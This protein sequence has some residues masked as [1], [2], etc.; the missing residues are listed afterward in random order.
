[1][2][3]T[4]EITQQ[5]LIFHLHGELDLHTAP[6]FRREAERLFARHQRLS[7]VIIVLRKVSFV[8]SS[9]L[10]AILNLYRAVQSN[11]GRLVLVAPQPAV[12]RVL[13]FA[14]LLKIIDTVETESKALLRA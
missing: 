7:T 13:Q 12:Q 11:N 4:T 1:M 2:E 5:A 6:S 14:G 8:D 10:G 3:M 9:G